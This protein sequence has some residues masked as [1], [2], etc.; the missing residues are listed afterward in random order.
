MRDINWSLALDND[1]RIAVGT[2]QVVDY[3]KLIGVKATG[4]IEVLDYEELIGAAAASTITITAYASLSGK[5]FTIGTD[6]L[7]EGV[8]FT[9]GTS[10]NATATSLAAAIDALADVS[11]AAV[12]AVVTV[13]AAAVGRDG[14]AITL[15]TNATAGYTMPEAH[16]IGGLDHATITVGADTLVQGTDFTAETSNDVTATNI[17]AA[18]DALANFVSSA[19]TNDVSIEAAA[20]GTAGNA[21]LTAT[22]D[23]M[24]VSA[25]T[26]SGST[27]TGGRAQGTVVVGATTLTQ[28]TNFTAETSNTV[29]AT[30]IA[31]AIDALANIAS[32]AVGALITNTASAAGEAG[33]I[34]IT[35]NASDALTI[36]AM[37]GGADYF[38]SDELVHDENT[39]SVTY[40]V[41]LDS[42]TPG[43][44]PE[45]NFFIQAS[46]DN[47]NWKDIY[48][49]EKLAA[50]GEKTATISKNIRTY[51]RVKIEL[52]DAD[53][54]VTV[55]GATSD[56]GGEGDQSSPIARNIPTSLLCLLSALPTKVVPVS[57]QAL[58]I[59]AGAAG[60]IVEFQV[61]AWPILAADGGLYAEDGDSSLSFGTGTCF[62]TEVSSETEDADLANGEWYM[63]YATGRG[64]GR[65]ATTATSD[66]VSYKMLGVSVIE[67]YAPDAENN[68]KDVINTETH[69]S[70]SSITADTLLKTGSGKLFALTFSCTD[71]TP[72]A[73]SIDVYDNT[74][75]AGTKLFTWAIPA[76]YF[77]P[78][79]LPI[80][81]L[82]TN[83]LYVDFTT[84][85]DVAV[86]ASFR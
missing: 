73:G 55:H 38:Y 80:D 30:N 11:A 69:G 33:N 53:A 54:T 66:T 71:A 76:A 42:I 9:A 85:A 62:T 16:L 3:T 58:T 84:T 7:T 50:A 2:I 63:D 51:T 25:L 64:R 49:F 74:S 34:A 18:I 6:V 44:A 56:F 24:T 8:D 45:V 47:E 26:L 72:T 46:Y 5:T 65:K 29:T 70:G 21:A 35:T 75:A 10:N 81:V 17:A 14:N 57:G 52:I 32:A 82:F 67:N 36:T 77:V 59:P 48:K 1:D 31:A 12:G 83:G 15:A 37:S 27:L 43:S 4:S 68:D 78:F 40:T 28:G 86:V 41:K 60:V 13:T 22:W 23:N 61:Q 39:S 79:T 19:V 20:V